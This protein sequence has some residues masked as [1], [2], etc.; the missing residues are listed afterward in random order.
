MD[1]N[2]ME[3]ITPAN[4]P[5]GGLENK[6]AGAQTPEFE[7]AKE[8]PEAVA[9][10]ETRPAMVKEQPGLIMPAK[11]KKKPAI[12]A[13]ARDAITIKVE[14]ILADGLQDSYEK[15]SPIARQEFKLKGE[16]TATKIRDLLNET[17]IKAK[18]IFRLILEWLSLLP[19]INRF[20]LEQEAK[21]KTDKIIELKKRNEEKIL[22]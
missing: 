9:M 11:R 16:I 8:R 12:P 17:K 10:Q 21:I 15:L 7:V 14:K 5:E 22:P 20:F 19:G 3:Q 2:Q 4:E 18:K 6:T 1:P 13:P